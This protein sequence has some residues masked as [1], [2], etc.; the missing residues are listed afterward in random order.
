M[1]IPY[2]Y[3]YIAVHVVIS[4]VINLFSVCITMPLAGSVATALI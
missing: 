3:V 1:A 2:T 4:A